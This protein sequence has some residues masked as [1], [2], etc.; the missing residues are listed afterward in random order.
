MRDHEPAQAQT[1]SSSATMDAYE[2][3]TD[4][5]SF[6]FEWCRLVGGNP[7]KGDDGGTLLHKICHALEVEEING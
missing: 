4:P 2:S 5:E 6:L 3:M 1:E 7:K